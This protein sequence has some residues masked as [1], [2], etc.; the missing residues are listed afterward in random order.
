ML[1]G[2]TA[3]VTAALISN[4]LGVASDAYSGFVL[5]AGGAYTVPPKELVFWIWYLAYGLSFVALFSVGLEQLGMT[6]RLAG[7]LRAAASWKHWPLVL[8]LVAGATSVAVRQWV[9]KQQV[10]SDD[11]E[12]YLFGAR[13]ILHG[14]LVNPLPAEPEF[15]QNQWI[16]MNT[17]GWFSKYPPGHSLVLALGMATHT[18]DLV[19][20]ALGAV[21]A[22][23][24][25]KL[26]RALVGPRRALLAL[27]LVV[28]SP[29]FTWTHAT[30]LSQP[31]STFA[32]IAASL[33]VAKRRSSAAMRW[34]AGAALG[35]GVLARPAPVLLFVP[36]VMLHVLQ[37]DWKLG[38]RARLLGQLPLVVPVGIGAAAIGVVNAVQAG[39]P[40]ESG[41]HSFHGYLGFFGGALPSQAGQ[42]VFAAVLR[43][44]FWLFGWPLSLLP[45]FFSRP[46]RGQALLWGPLLGQLVYRLVM[47]KT[48][49]ST[50]GPVYIVETIPV[51]SL[52]AADGLARLQVLLGRWWK[53]P[54][55]EQR[56]MT[57]TVA[58][59]VAALAMFFPVVAASV[60]RGANARLV[61]WNALAQ[62]GATRAVVFTQA[63]VDPKANLSWAYYAPNPDPAL[64]EP[65]IFLR[66]PKKMSL[67]QVRGFAQR[68]FPD[69]P[70][71]QFIP[72]PEPVLI[73]LESA[74]AAAPEPVP[75]PN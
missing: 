51:L 74:P 25:Y 7:A 3:L 68:T 56:L 57:A 6:A 72:A 59:F 16:V 66:W 73:P 53:A 45:V 29:H 18:L 48:V 20:P 60:T 1:L 42:S 65:V 33:A 37:A 4:A 12:A 31:T 35:F 15:F 67:E 24:T 49:V 27:V 54:R 13:T 39:S 50:T 8:P 52:L 21:T 9:L 11:E 63:L 10:V 58:S 2:L 28:L 61:V 30:L 26:A 23:L 62:V 46:K 34:L 22:W 69:R 19:L 71:F 40:L 43:E 32:L 17:K 5:P 41:Y 75:A 14:R 38:L 70:A 44:N 47:P 55:T 36:A 64:D